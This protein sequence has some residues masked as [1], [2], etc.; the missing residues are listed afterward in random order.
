MKLDDPKLT[1]FALGELSEREIADLEQHSQSD[2][3]IAA[4]IQETREIAE[5]LRENLQNEPAG[6]LAPHQRDA[7]F[8][9]ARIAT[10]QVRPEEMTA[11]R[12]VAIPRWWDRP[13]PW[14]AIAACLITAFA[15]YAL[16]I[17][18][19][20]TGSRQQLAGVSEL[21]MPVPMDATAQSTP[22]ASPNLISP[23]H[24]T[25]VASVPAPQIDRPRIGAPAPDLRAVAPAVTIDQ[26]K[27][28]A[29]ASDSPK[30]AP[31]AAGPSNEAPVA[32]RG[33]RVVG[34]GSPQVINRMAAAS[35][36]KAE[37][38][39]TLVSDESAAQYLK[40]RM[41]EAAEMQAGKSFAE[42]SQVFRPVAGESGRYEMIRLPAI[43]VDA[44]FAPPAGQTLSAPPAPESRVTR[45]SKPYLE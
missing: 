10:A 16:S 17:N 25:S 44:E 2:R 43:K 1:A 8:R 34:N 45:V 28:F 15:V 18:P 41:Q 31:V 12:V 11:G 27:N 40:A 20:R 23:D 38:K 14:Q 13:G 4:E 22:Q 39:G 21:V 35:V 30:P 37:Q 7:I 19:S 29:S 9:A 32:S 5:I 36:A 3:E 24:R 42:F 33:P 26:P 6:E